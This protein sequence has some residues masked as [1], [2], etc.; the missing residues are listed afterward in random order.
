MISKKWL[1]LALTTTMMTTGLLA[2]AQQQ[3]QGQTRGRSA[4]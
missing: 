2:T 1:C 3:P 4:R